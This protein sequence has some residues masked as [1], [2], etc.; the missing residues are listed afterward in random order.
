[1]TWSNF[2]SIGAAE[3]EAFHTRYPVLVRV[4]PE[5]LTSLGRYFAD[6]TV[7]QMGRAGE[8]DIRGWGTIRL[9]FESL[10]AARGRLLAF[11]RAVE[12]LEPLPLRKSLVDFAEQI[13]DFYNR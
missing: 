8:D 4:A 11:G 7:E 10:E 6:I 1:M 12:V 2:G 3:N 13:V 5:I 9:S